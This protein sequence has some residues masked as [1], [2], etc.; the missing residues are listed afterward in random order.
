MD[1]PCNGFCSMDIMV[2]LYRAM[3]G[4]DRGDVGTGRILLVFYLQDVPNEQVTTTLEKLAIVEVLLRAASILFRLYHFV[5]SCVW[6]ECTPRLHTE[7]SRLRGQGED[8]HAVS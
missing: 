1:D 3:G 6:G 7:R 2:V 5:G 8:G 4:A